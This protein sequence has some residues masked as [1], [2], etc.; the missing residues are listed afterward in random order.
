ME[1]IPVVYSCS[2]C[3]SVAQLANDIAITL[4]REHI[5]EMSCIAGL[6]GDVPS[7]VKKAKSSTNIIA[8][9]GCHLRCTKETL[10]RHE[11]IAAVE[12]VLTDFGLKK[13]LEQNVSAIDSMFVYKKV[14]QI[15]ESKI[16]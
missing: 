2:G 10:A 5:A 6:G 1:T 4:D 12:I 9:D 11:I 16:P 13:K 15:I 3:S 7:L 8:I 14:F